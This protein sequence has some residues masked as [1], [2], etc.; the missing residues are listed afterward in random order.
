M[1]ILNDLAQNLGLASRPMTV[2]HD[3]DGWW[4]MVADM[5]RILAG[6]TDS[7]WMDMH[8]REGK[9][10]A[11]A[12]CTPLAMVLDKLGSMSSRAVP[13][14]MD[15]DGNELERYADMKHLL[16]RPNPM[17]DFGAFI[18][19]VEINLKL[20]GFCP[21]LTTRARAAALPRA[22]WVL[23]PEA[24]HLE[25]TG[26]VLGE[27]EQDGVVKRAYVKHNNREIVLQ[28]EDYF[29]IFDGAVVYPQKEGK[30]ILFPTAADSLS[31]DVS[32]WTAA[33]KA[34]HTLL[35]HGG[36]KGVLYSDYAD[37]M[38]NSAMGSAE[39][40]EMRQRFLNEYGLTGQEY[41]IMVTRHKVGW[42]P[43]DYNADQLKIQENDQ[44]CT[45]RICNTLGVNANLFSDA[46]YDNQESAKKGAYQDIIIPDGKKIA[47]A[48][49][50]ALAQGTDAHIE[51]DYTD[52]ECL[53]KDKRQEAATLQTAGSALIA[54]LNAGVI[55]AEETRIEIANYI[56]IDPL[57]PMGA[58]NGNAGAQPSVAGSVDGDKDDE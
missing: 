37:D 52:V 40:Q 53:Q 57:L 15:A 33:Q 25:G 41:P 34:T 50:D 23:A 54:L 46:K 58:R 8:T 27:Y 4:Y 28:P 24:F 26:H 10:L 7:V 42:L 45:E 36:P 49:T 29:V 16:E 13:Y 18:K 20:F 9:S 31:S 2:Q 55:T 44:R 47:S 1:G 6:S 56:D 43:L 35:V 3:A 51:L 11:L 5:R 38:G 12:Q 32:I 17:Q 22:M 19:Q 48:L 14:V 30:E 39:E 21:V